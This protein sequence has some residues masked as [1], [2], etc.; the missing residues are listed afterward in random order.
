MVGGC[1]NDFEEINTNNN[2]P[3]TVSPNLI[4]SQVISSSVSR[5]TIMG[6][7]NGNIV[8]QLTAKINFTGFDRYD[9]GSESGLWNDLYGNLPE[10]EIILQTSREEAPT[11]TSYEGIALVLKSWIYSILTDNWGA[12]PYSEAIK[13]QTDGNF[14]PVYDSQEGHL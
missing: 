6:W 2:Q 1:T 14:Q 5:A 4:L 3:E 13:G 12:V 9:W 11:N 7:N 10:L 8:A